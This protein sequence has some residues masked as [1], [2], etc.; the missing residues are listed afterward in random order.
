MLVHLSKD[1]IIAILSQVGADAS[2]LKKLEIKGI[3][4]ELKEEMEQNVLEHEGLNE[5][6]WLL[7]GEQSQCRI[8][9]L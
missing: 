6:I 9:P 4:E 7:N 8:V 3:L 5:S 2:K 1:Q